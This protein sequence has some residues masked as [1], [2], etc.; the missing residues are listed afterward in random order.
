M[1]ENEN[2]RRI[3]IMARRERGSGGDRWRRK[4]GKE[5]GD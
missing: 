3:I 2:E 4:I 1:E 5:Q